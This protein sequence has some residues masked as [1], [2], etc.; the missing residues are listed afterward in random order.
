MK[1]AI[2]Q[3]YFFPYIGYFQLINAVD[4]FVV[5]DDVNFQTRSWMNRNYILSQGSAQRITLELNGASQNKKINDIKIGNKNKRIVET[6]RHSYATAP[7]FDD[8]YPLVKSLLLQEE[9]NLALFLDYQLRDLCAYLGLCP[10]W[11]ISSALNKETQLSGQERILEIC[12]LL[13]A[14]DYI[15][16]PGGRGLYDPIAFKNREI[17]LSFLNTKNISYEQFRPAFVPNL[18]IIDVMMF[19]APGE[20]REKFLSAY[21]LV[22]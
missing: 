11:H 14:A 19:N 10:A 18:S 20:I 22:S 7:F 15:N 2:M 3:P 1:L 13:G 5:Y 17:H 6:I 12:S 4:V 21:D 9:K 16:A 8:V